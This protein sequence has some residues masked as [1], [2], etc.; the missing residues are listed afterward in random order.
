MAEQPSSELFFN[1]ACS[2]CGYRQVKLPE[3]LPV[4]GDDFDWLVRDYDGFRLFMLEELAARFP[5]R[6]RWT[7]ADMEVVIV[8]TLS[9]VLDQLSDMLDRVQA[10][11]FLETARRPESV[12]RLLAMIGYDAVSQAAAEAKIPD[13]DG[14]AGE[15]DAARRIRL[16]AFH[17]PLQRYLSDYQDVVDELT[18]AQQSGLQAFI[19]NPLSATVAALDAVQQFL[20]NAPDFVLRARNET[21]HSF[22]TLYP[23]EMEK[24]RTLGPRSIHMQKRMVTED[25]YAERLEDHPLVL[26]AHAYN[27]WTGS[28]NTVYTAVVISEN[29]ML[30]SPLT[31]AAVGGVDSFQLLQASVDQFNRRYELDDVDWMAEPTPRIILRPY[32]DAYRMAAQEVFLQ[33]ARFVGINIALSV[34]V[35]GNYFQSEIRRDINFS[36]G[37]ELGGFFAPGRLAFGEDVHAGDIIE[38]IMSLDGV[39]AVCLNRFKRVGRRY[40]NQADSGRIR[41]EGLEIAT[42]NNDAQQPALGILRVILHGGQRG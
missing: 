2:D 19:D 18:P 30:D 17:L 27:C 23:H 24:A 4:V 1:D 33:D 26:R 38:A 8:E 13:A 39:D 12:R 20:D 42:C 35:A 3:P 5:Q 29:L 40:P 11:A 31:V 6:R 7:P 32:L 25:D 22:W 41:L 37:T 14:A 28:W 15:S 10:E 9:V 16:R 34:R 36:L 21:L